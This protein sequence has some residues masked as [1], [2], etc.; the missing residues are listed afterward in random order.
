MDKPPTVETNAFSPD[1]PD[2]G[3]LD[4]CFGPIWK[5][6]VASNHSHYVK[7]ST[8]DAED[9]AGAMLAKLVEHFDFSILIGLS[10]QDRERRIFGYL[11]SVR[12]TVAAD[13][14]AE[15][16]PEMELIEV[17]V[18]P[19]L[20]AIEFGS[21]DAAIEPVSDHPSLVR[22]ALLQLNKWDRKLVI[23]KAIHGWTYPEIQ[24][25][26]KKSR[27]HVEIGALKMRYPRALNQLTDFVKR[28]RS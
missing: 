5:K 13:F 21:S 24:E 17:S 1:S 16:N 7:L 20:D 9:M 28:Q 18:E 26:F 19:G 3:F 6:L 27:Y 23:H 8:Q 10:I 15:R 2:L 25:E 14:F 12:R 4:A 22:K 11:K